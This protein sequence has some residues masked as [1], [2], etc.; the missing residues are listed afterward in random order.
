LGTK[1]S[2]VYREAGQQPLEKAH[3][4]KNFAFRRVAPS[5]QAQR[6]AERETC[7]GMHR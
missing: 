7:D 5:G 6:L 3:D 2:D 1:D 4:R